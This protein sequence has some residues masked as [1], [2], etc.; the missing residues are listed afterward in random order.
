M[1][2]AK[3]QRVQGEQRLVVSALAVVCLIATDVDAVAG[4]LLTQAEPHAG[5]RGRGGQRSRLG[6]VV[7][8]DRHVLH[9]LEAEDVALKVA[10]LIPGEAVQVVGPDVEQ[11]GNVWA[12]RGHLKLRVAD[13][14]HYPG[15]GADL[16]QVVKDA[17]A[18][19]A[20]DEY[21]LLVGAEHLAQKGGGGG[22]AAGAGDADNGAGTELHEQ[23][24]HR[25]DRDAAAEDVIQSG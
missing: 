21:G 24:E 9:G 17:Y 22:L 18:D 19:V 8:E 6:I 10:V 2:A 1:A 5:A 3:G 25:P 16:R 15:V 12:A 11:A 4:N 7:V 14:Q 13:L 23:G 20:S